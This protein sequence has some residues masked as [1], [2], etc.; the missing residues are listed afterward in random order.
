MFGQFE[1]D[2]LEYYHRPLYSDFG[3]YCNCNDP[4]LA[5]RG[6][7]TCFNQAV[8]EFYQMESWKWS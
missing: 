2:F 7:Q 4:D 1:S 5:T 3:W 6:C 8:L